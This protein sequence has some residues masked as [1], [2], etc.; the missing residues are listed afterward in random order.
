M[1]Y[2]FIINLFVDIN[3]FKCYKTHFFLPTRVPSKWN[4][5]LEHRQF[6]SKSIVAGVKCDAETIKDVFGL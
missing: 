1:E 6:I 4:N 5:L 3:V 2:V